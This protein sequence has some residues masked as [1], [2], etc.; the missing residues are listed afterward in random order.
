MRV[1]SITSLRLVVV[2][3]LCALGALSACVGPPGPTG[4]AGAA[5][6]PGAMG[7]MGSAGAQGPKGDPAPEPT[8]A[9][10]VYTLSND[11]SGNEIVVYTRAADGSLTPFNSYST[12]GLGASAGL[13]DQGGLA[14]DPARKLFF[15][16]NAGDDSVSM[17]G[18][19]ND[20][21]V[22]LI[23]KIGSGGSRPV[24]VTVFGETLYVLNAGAFPATGTAVPGN[25]AGFKINAGGLTAIANSTQHLSV[26]TNTGPAQVSFS[27]DGKLL[28]VTEKA[29]SKIVVYPVSNG[30]AGASKVNASRGNIPFGFAFTDAS[31][32]VVSEVNDPTMPVSSVTS[33][34]LAADGTAAAVTDKYAN[35]QEAAC[36]SL[37]IGTHAFV[38]NTHSNNISSFDIGSNGALTFKTNTTVGTWP[39]EMA[40]TQKGDFLYTL[41]AGPQNIGTTIRSLTPVEVTADGALSKRPDF[42]GL[43]QF[44]VGLVVR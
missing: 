15:A 8:A 2:P 25:I 43:P 28:V 14:F 7:A 41:N 31:H 26:D 29:T 5:G 11:K 6:A 21:S 16:V 13:G 4:P 12:G 1:S 30:V 27:P 23:S 3:L 34:S 9:P 17:L 32:I 35:S 18:L 20:G 37:V 33:Y 39:G 36:W 19:R 42:V 38:T 22:A 40:A 44:A 10:A 24:S